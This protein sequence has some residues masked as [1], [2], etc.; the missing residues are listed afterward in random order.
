MSTQE[1][2]VETPAPAAP[3]QPRKRSKAKKPNVEP[4]PAVVES[5][6]SST[7]AWADEPLYV[8]S[9]QAEEEK[10]QQM[11]DIGPVSPLAVYYEGNAGH[12]PSG[13]GSTFWE[14]LW[15]IGLGFAAGAFSA[16][17]LMS[18]LEA[19]EEERIVNSFKQRAL[20]S[21]SAAEADFRAAQTPE[22]KQP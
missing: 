22:Q 13:G 2:I 10:E 8:P 3:K 5:I 18:Y 6:E 17:G 9:M 19:L 14:A 4:A 15:H 20:Q 21:I 7:P 1:T 11:D 16:L 12:V